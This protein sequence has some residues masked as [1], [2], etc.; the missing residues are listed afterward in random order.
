MRNDGK[1]PMTCTNGHPWTPANTAFDRQGRRCC[2]T[3]ARE[4]MTRTRDRD[5]LVA[6][7]QHRVTS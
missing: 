3:C 4:R 7:Y 2:R 5:R 1:D 6:P